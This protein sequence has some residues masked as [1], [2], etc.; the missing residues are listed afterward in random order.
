MVQEIGPHI[1]SV[2]VCRHLMETAIKNH[3]GLESIAIQNL[4]T[5]SRGRFY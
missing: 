3:F 1:A 4:S 2:V 5:S